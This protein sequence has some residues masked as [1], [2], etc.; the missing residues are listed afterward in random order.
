MRG[1]SMLCASTTQHCETAAAQGQRMEVKQTVFA[2]SAGIMARIRLAVKGQ[3]EVETA[4]SLED[5]QTGVIAQVG[6]PAALAMNWLGD[7]ADPSGKTAYTLYYIVQ[8]DV[9]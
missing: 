8:A 7:A 5:G 2:S 4:V 9:P 1:T 3:G 6:F